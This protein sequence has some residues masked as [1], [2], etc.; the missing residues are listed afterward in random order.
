MSV[1]RLVAFLS[2]WLG[3]SV[4][5]TFKCCWWECLSGRDGAPNG[6]IEFL[7]VPA[8]LLATSFRRTGLLQS[9]LIPHH[10]DKKT[11]V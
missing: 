5:G 7:A 9:T 11:A 1:N 8:Q 10:S 3:V 2:D 4:R 6:R